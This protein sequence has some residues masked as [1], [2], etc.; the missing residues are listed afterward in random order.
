VTDLTGSL[1]DPYHARGRTQKKINRITRRI[2][3][4]P[5]AKG[6]LPG[7]VPIRGARARRFAT[8][9]VQTKVC[10]V[11]GLQAG[12]AATAIGRKDGQGTRFARTPR[13]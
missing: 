1:I 5:Q 8:V 7:E 11:C 12:A 4:S 6:V 9:R 13:V 10:R 2:R 3:H